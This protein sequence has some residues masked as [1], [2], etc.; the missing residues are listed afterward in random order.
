MTPQTLMT[1]TKLL[2]ENNEQLKPIINK[3]KV[4]Y[5][6]FIFCK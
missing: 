3:L 1:E 6:S 2:N 5:L 4:D